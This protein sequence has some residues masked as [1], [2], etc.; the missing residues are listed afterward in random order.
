MTD[1]VVVTVSTRAAHGQRPDGVGPGLVARL[2]ADQ[3]SVTPEPIV[4]AD[5]QPALAALL[6]RLAAEHRLIVTTGGTGLSPS[7]RT[8]EATTDV[9]DRLVPGMAEL[10]R[11]VGMV[12]TPLAALSRGVVGVLGRTLIVNL[13]GSPHGAMESLEAVLP[14]LRHAVE[15]LAGTDH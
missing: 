6:G 1:A 2:A 10:M 5:D 13:P 15:Q 3:W 12:S 9:A 8:P 4:V 14:V 11:G 7:D